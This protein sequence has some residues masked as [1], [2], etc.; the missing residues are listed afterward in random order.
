MNKYR[1]YSKTETCRI[2]IKSKHGKFVVIVDES[3][4]ERISKHRW[5]IAKTSERQTYVASSIYDKETKKSKTT[6]LHRLVASAPSGM[7]VDHIDGNT[8]NN[9]KS[10]LRLCTQA[11][12]QCN[13]GPSRHSK[14]GFKGVFMTESQKALSRPW[15]AKI[16]T[17]G[18]DHHLGF[19]ASPEEA[20]KAYD[21]KATELQGEFAKLN[22]PP[23]EK[24]K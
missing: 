22:F 19:F 21:K 2:Y 6:Y 7:E 20:A 16:Y 23:N 9:R 24:G 11:E 17:N 10:N 15:Q 5:Y 12:N 1:H 4:F 8:L 18:K 14:S 3:D 13:R